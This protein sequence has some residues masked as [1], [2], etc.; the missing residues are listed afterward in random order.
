MVAWIT[1]KHIRFDI[2]IYPQKL[3]LAY[4]ISASHLNVLYDIVNNDK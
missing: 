3:S 2:K 4:V 1:I